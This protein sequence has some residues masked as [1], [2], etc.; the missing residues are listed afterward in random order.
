MEEDSF[1]P[2]WS[3]DGTRIAFWSTVEVGSQE[4]RSAHPTFLFVNQ[5]RVVEIQSRQVVALA[6]SHFSDNDR[7]GC[8]FYRLDS[9]WSPDSSKLM[10]MCSSWQTGTDRI[11]ALG[12]F[13][14]HE[15]QSVKI[16]S[17]REAEGEIGD[18]N[19]IGWSP[20][21]ETVVWMYSGYELP[22]EFHF[23]A[24]SGEEELTL[25]PGNSHRNVPWPRWS[26]DSSL[27]GWVRATQEEQGYLGLYVWDRVPISTTVE[28]PAG[29]EWLDLYWVLK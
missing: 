4:T 25:R 29:V 24:L 22:T 20:S 2:R 7:G 13:D 10:W 18:W 5:V 12:L 21:S 8:S 14:F 15:E 11:R 26:S 27:L 6:P 23:R 28:L 3:P 17:I 1:S 19:G 9:V 16:D